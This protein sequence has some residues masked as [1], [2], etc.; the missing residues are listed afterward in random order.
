MFGPTTGGNAVVFHQDVPE[1]AKKEYEQGVKSIEKGAFD[2]A[3]QSLKRSI[4]LFPTYYDAL[5]RLGSEY[6]VRDDAQ[7]A[8]PLLA[9]AVEVNR[10]GW[11]G[12]YFLGIAQNKVNHLAESI[13]SLQRAVELNPDSPHTNM[14]L[15]M[16]LAVDPSMQANAIQS[17]EKAAKM[18]KEP[19]PGQ[20]YYY[21][22]GLYMRNNQYKEAADAFETLLRVSPNI[23]EK[24]KIKNII[25]QLRQK[26]KEQNKK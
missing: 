26:A 16:V 7:S 1:A 18:A 4:E 23:G 24:E 22:G 11:R 14:W 15:G 9:R 5:E 3:A 25:G 13:K 21:L 6:V 8:I 20:A 17:L 19:L 10:D 12:F 2:S